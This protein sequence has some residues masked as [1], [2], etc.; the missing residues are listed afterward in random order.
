[1]DKTI[2]IFE[3]FDKEIKAGFSTKSY[4]NLS[5]KWSGLS[6][7][8]NREKFLNDQDLNL[9]DLIMVEQIHEN[10]IVVVDNKLKGRGVRKT[11]WLNGAEG[12]VTKDASV[13][14]GVETA[15][16]LPVFACAPTSGVIGV[17]HAGWRSVLQGVVVN[18]VDG[19]LSLGAS[20]EEIFIEIGPH[21]KSCCFEIKDDVLSQFDDYEDCVEKQMF[22][23]VVNLAKIVLDQLTEVGLMAQN[24]KC[25]D[26][27]TCCNHNFYSFRRDKSE[28]NG[29]ML[30]VISLN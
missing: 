21:I 10:K 2:K 9:E 1:M 4:G 5:F 29:S 13:V 14:L 30:G 17:A 27:C 7:V 3:K 15:D 12:M 8:E 6:V 24:I 11:D 18:L 19:M 23:S 26:L 28:C 20:K 22:G 25:S 16:C